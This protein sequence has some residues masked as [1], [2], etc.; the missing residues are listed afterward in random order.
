MSPPLTLTTAAC[1][2]DPASG[3]G[4]PAP[5][6]PI[7]VT[8]MTG[9]EVEIDGPVDDYAI[10]TIDV[11]D[12]VVPVIGED[13]FDKLV[14]VGNSGGKD[15]YDAV[16]DPM[17]PDMAERVGIISE[18]NAPFDVEMLLAKQP[19]VLIVNSAMQAHRHAL[20]I[21]EQ[22]TAAG[23]PLVLIDVPGDIDGS[24]R[25][26]VHLIGEIFGEEERAGEVGDFID[27]Q[28]D[29]LAGAGIGSTGDA[30][31]LYYEKSGTLESVGTSATSDAS[32]WGA[33]FAMAGGS[34][35]ADGAQAGAP[36]AARGPGVTVD[37]ELVLTQDPDFVFLSG[38][39]SIGLD[40][41]PGIVESPD[42]TILDRP[43]WDR[44]P[45]V[46][47][48]NVY[49]FQHELS[50]GAVS[51]YPVLKAAKIMHPDKLAD[52]DP[53][54]LL[55]DFYDKFMLI[56]ADEGVW[57]LQAPVAADASDE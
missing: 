36:E 26:A 15:A 32:G 27:A 18:H 57:F 7:T 31:S 28:F 56:D 19:D 9:R 46:A 6:G 34:N 51:F 1:A 42:F 25:E 17:F 14:G 11:V 44:L 23:I 41:D 43:G 40:S 20:D 50:R 35:I 37:P 4:A 38:T 39:N 55:A 12:F 33:V 8:D 13:A 49:E 24:S 48:G 54:R 21:E 29:T 22:L 3:D 5:A 10:S 45:A 16:Y 53:D 52:V 47:D 30:P 2:T